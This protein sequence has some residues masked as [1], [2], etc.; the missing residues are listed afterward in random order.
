[1]ILESGNKIHVITRRAFDSDTP[2]HFVAEVLEVSDTLVSARG[3]AS[4][5]IPIATSSRNGRSP[6]CGSSRW[7]TP[8]T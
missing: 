8:R 5:A 4:S 3:Y 6:A 2:R 7:G 1:M